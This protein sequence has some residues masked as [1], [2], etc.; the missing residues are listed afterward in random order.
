MRHDDIAEAQIELKDAARAF[1]KAGQLHA[2]PVI[3]CT[4]CNDL[5]GQRVG[6]KNNCVISFDCA[7]IGKDSLE[8]FR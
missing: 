8:V 2:N 4:F 5:R 3:V 6:I 7:Y 1:K